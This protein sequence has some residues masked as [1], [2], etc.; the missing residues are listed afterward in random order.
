MTDQP[1]ILTI[2]DDRGQCVTIDPTGLVRVD[3]IPVFRAVASQ[4]GVTLQFK[5]RVHHQRRLVEIPLAVL[6][7]RIVDGVS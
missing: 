6:V 1:P 3:G 2:C 7:D 5:E 4:A